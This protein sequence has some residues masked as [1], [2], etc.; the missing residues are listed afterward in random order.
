M[1]TSIEAINKRSACLKRLKCGL[2][3][4]YVSVSGLKRVLSGSELIGGMV[5]T[6]GES[7]RSIFELSCQCYKVAIY[8]RSAI[9]Y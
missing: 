7:Q 4:I 5:A 2:R 3:S 9:D 1:V 8:Q 6:R